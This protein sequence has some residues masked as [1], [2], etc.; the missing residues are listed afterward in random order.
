MA[1]RASKRLRHRAERKADFQMSLGFIIAVVFAIVLLTLAITWLQQVIGNISGI[2]DDLTKQAQSKIQ[3]TFNTQ[4]TNFA[5]WPPQYSLSAGKSLKLLAGIRNDEPQGNTINY[6][7]NVIPADSSLCQSGL[8]VDAQ[9]NPKPF[10]QCQTAKGESVSALMRS[11][12]TFDRTL[13]TVQVGTTAYK[14][15]E[16][17]PPNNA[18]K[19]TYI[20]T[21]VACTVPSGTSTVN[22]ADCT[23]TSPNLWGNPQSLTIEV[24]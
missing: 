16:V 7:I 14:S 15:V 1:R 17:G 24:T 4:N 18:P 19:E 10:S 9:G 5:V 12:I 23:A 20:Y 22:S 21:A 8:N 3:E 13:S 2:T 6:Y 11:W